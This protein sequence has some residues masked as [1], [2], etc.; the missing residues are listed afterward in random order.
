MDY[1]EPDALPRGME[2]PA[3]LEPQ[4]FVDNYL[5]ALL[6]QAFLL[7]SSAFHDVVTQHGL[8]VAEWRVLA[9]LAGGRV[10]SIGQLAKIAVSKQSTVTRMLDRMTK[11]GHVERLAHDSDRRITLVRITAAGNATV[12]HLIALAREHEERVLQP[13]GSAAADELKR[14]LR[15]LIETNSLPAKRP[16]QAPRPARSGP[17][18]RQEQSEAA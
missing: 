16:A 1:P 11:K 13:L 4:P 10:L 14:L 15:Q 7:I 17:A 9:T 2:L 18:R 8:S 6:G 3:R 12:A 5:A